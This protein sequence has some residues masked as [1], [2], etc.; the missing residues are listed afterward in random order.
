MC[1]VLIA[2][3]TAKCVTNNHH[4]LWLCACTFSGTFLNIFISKFA[5]RT[6][7]YGSIPSLILKYL[8]GADIIS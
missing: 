2:S 8:A 7:L 6:N 5:M 4:Q 1:E 3:L